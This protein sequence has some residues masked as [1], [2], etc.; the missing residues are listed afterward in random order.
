MRY[1]CLAAA[2]LAVMLATL[3]AQKAL[4]LATEEIGNEP[5]SELN[6][7]EWPGI[8][9]LVNDKNRV[10]SIWVN[11]NEWF[12]YK[13]KHDEVNAA[14]AHFV[15][16]KVEHHVV[17]LRAGPA[18]VRSFEKKEFAYN[19]SLHAVGGIAQVRA[20]DDPDDL[21]WQRD[22][23][24]TIYIDDTI[25]LDKLDFP[26]GVTLRSAPATTDA[27]M[28]NEAAAIRIADFLKARNGETPP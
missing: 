22:P 9:P 27:G 28:K 15:K 12:Y 7:A 21:D 2:V 8:M 10:Y 3:P 20:V 23:V 18:T 26:M 4:A 14:L 24:L 1:T 5:L 25:D 6:Y 13:G 19:W 17:A 11:G 16:M